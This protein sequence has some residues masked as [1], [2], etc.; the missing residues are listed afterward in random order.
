MEAAV[1]DGLFGMISGLIG[2][3]ACVYVGQPMDT[4]KVK[5]QTFPDIHKN[6]FSCIK[7][8]WLKEGIIRGFYAGILPA[9]SGGVSEN[10]AL[11]TAMPFCQRLVTYFSGKESVKELNLLQL[12]TA[13]SCCGFFTSLVMCPN[14]LIKC[15]MQSSR[16]VAQLTKSNVL[17]TQS[18]FWSVFRGIISQD[19]PKGLYKG[20]TCTLAREL[21]GLFLYV[22][23]N[24]TARFLM[25]PPH[26][27]TDDLSPLCTAIAG[28][29]GGFCLW[30]VIFPLDA[31][32]SRIQVGRTSAASFMTSE[33]NMG[34]F[35][36]PSPRVV[37]TLVH[38]LRTE[39]IGSLYNGLLP[40]LFRTIPST[41]TL[42]VV[43][44]ETKKLGRKLQHRNDNRP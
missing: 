42:F 21:P 13:G 12:A 31:V 6:A 24:E 14:E 28:G 23:G 4:I 30:S 19:G 5:M 7:N 44:E 16:E 10:V 8:I 35:T 29:F 22:G 32:K 37:A 38:I 39:G 15:K 36:T 20:Y 18:S 40:T 11:F 41:A 1:S 43:V 27:A 9:L 2:G 34:A 26:K 3:V 17:Q 25:T 33:A